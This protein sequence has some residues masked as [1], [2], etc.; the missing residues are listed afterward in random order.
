[1]AHV[2]RAL[3]IAVVAFA[4][5]LS[6]VG[7]SSAAQSPYNFGVNV[8]VEYGPTCHKDKYGGHVCGA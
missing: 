5:A 8:N 1:M 6:G 3:P 2:P 4:A 7:I